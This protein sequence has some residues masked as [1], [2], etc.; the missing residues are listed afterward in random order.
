MIAVMVPLVAATVI[1]GLGALARRLRSTPQRDLDAY[2]RGRDA[3][4]RLNGTR[5]HFEAI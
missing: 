5:D 1:T 2:A 4:T 3:L